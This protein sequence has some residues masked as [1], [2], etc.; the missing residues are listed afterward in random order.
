MELSDRILKFELDEVS[1]LVINPISGAIGIAPKKI[2]N[3][4]TNPTKEYLDTRGYFL[5]EDERN[6]KLINLQSVYEQH[7][8]NVPYWFYVLTTL[9]CNFECP[10]CYEKQ[11]LKNSETTPSKLEKI[12]KTISEFQEENQIPDKRMNLIVFG[13]EPLCVSNPNILDEI[14]E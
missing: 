12:I 2:L 14:L 9:N 5:S 3:N 7:N 6:N 13:G 10:I 11:T 8:K 1:T 4:M